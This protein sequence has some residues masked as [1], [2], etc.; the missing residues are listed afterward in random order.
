[1]RFIAGFFVGHAIAVLMFT[2]NEGLLPEFLNIVQFFELDHWRDN[3]QQQWYL[4][5]RYNHQS[6][7]IYYCAKLELNIIKVLDKGMT[8][9]IALYQAIG[10]ILM[11][12]ANADPIVIEYYFNFATVFLITNIIIMLFVLYLIYV[13]LNKQIANIILLII[14]ICVLSLLIRILIILYL[15]S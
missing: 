11:R 8:S 9:V 2:P 15:S 1:M 14:I 7:L 10:N 13:N 5:H 4:N 12:H 6:P 3:L